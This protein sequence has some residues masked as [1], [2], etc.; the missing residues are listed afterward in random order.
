MTPAAEEIGRGD[1]RLG[2]EILRI[3]PGVL[4]CVA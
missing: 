3:M 1:H 2:V 4:H